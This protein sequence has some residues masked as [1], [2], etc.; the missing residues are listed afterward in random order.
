MTLTVTISYN[1]ITNSNNNNHNDNNNSNNNNNEMHDVFM[2]VIK[3]FNTL[4]YIIY[5]H[6]Y[7]VLIFNKYVTIDI[8]FVFLLHSAERRNN[9]YHFF[10]LMNIS[11]FFVV[12][13]HLYEFIIRP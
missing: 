4:F 7:D 12:A 5:F 2:A 6:F 10:L 8:V 3:L 13:P 9:I 1:A 11:S